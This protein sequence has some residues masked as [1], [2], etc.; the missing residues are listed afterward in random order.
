MTREERLR[1]R[2]VKA[3]QREFIDTIKKFEKRSKFIEICIVNTY[4]GLC[5]MQINIKKE[6]KIVA[7][8]V[9]Y[10]KSF[11]DYQDDE[12]FYSYDDCAMEDDE[13]EWELK[14]EICVYKNF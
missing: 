2:E 6:N 13:D 14:F 4:W 3:L 12:W 1:I 7:E 9:D 8:M 11:C 5:A 10:I